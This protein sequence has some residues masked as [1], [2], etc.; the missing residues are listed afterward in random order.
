MLRQT[1]WRAHVYRRRLERAILVRFFSNVL[2]KLTSHGIGSSNVMIQNALK[3]ISD[4]LSNCVQ[5]PEL[6]HTVIEQQLST[7]DI[8]FVIVFYYMCWVF[9]RVLISHKTRCIATI[10]MHSILALILG[11]V[12]FKVR[13]EL[14][15]IE[16][17]A[18]RDRIDAMF[19]DTMKAMH[20]VQQFLIMIRDALKN[21]YDDLRDKVDLDKETGIR[22]FAMTQV[23]RIQNALND[24]ETQF[25]FLK[26][27]PSNLT[28]IGHE[29]L[30]YLKQES[31]VKCNY[32]CFTYFWECEYDTYTN[33]ELLLKDFTILYVGMIAMF[34]TVVKP[35]LHIIRE[36]TEARFEHPVDRAE[37][38]LFEVSENDLEDTLLSQLAKYNISQ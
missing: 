1:L 36:P 35:V 23:S 30:T 5:Q 26:G 28:T 24:T 15:F 12:V 38:A 16:N 3:L 25:D 31:A 9:I 11:S 37:F 20:A 19:D 33:L 18:K 8:E 7:A 21:V 13:S 34:Q 29:V 22:N 4:L 14:H 6:M 17:E 27:I 10:M 32:Y 2:L